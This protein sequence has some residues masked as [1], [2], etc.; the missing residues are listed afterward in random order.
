MVVGDTPSSAG[1]FT[2]AGVT[3]GPGVGAA[4]AMLVP[5]ASITEIPRPPTSADFFALG[6]R[7]EAIFRFLSYQ[8]SSWI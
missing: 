7:R 1:Q 6:L 3:F 2:G 5:S 8:S 4:V